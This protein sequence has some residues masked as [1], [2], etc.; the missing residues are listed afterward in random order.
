MEEEHQ[1]DLSKFTKFSSCG[2]AR[3][4]EMQEEAATRWKSGGSDD[5]TRLDRGK[6][7]SRRHMKE[8]CWRKKK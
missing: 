2:K 5:E 3:E 6:Q 1:E 8:N 7:I 4:A